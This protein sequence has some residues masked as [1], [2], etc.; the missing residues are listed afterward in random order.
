[1][2][3]EH[4]AR[5]KEHVV[6]GEEHI[7]RQHQVIADLESDGHDT[8]QAREILVTLEHSQALHLRGENWL[9]KELAARA[10]N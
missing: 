2:I 9:T 3:L 4:L 7:R 6:E 1:M 8:T 5:A 10:G